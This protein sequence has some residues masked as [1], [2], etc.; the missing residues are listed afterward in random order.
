MD[1]KPSCSQC[2]QLCMAGLQGGLVDDILVSHPGPMWLRDAGWVALQNFYVHQ[3][4]DTKDNGQYLL[5]VRQD[6]DYMA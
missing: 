2:S 5:L 3:V 6:R 1:K 4:W